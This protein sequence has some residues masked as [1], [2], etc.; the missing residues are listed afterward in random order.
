MRENPEFFR[1]EN[2]KNYKFTQA[3]LS[4]TAKDEHTK[5]NQNQDTNKIAI[6]AK[7]D[8]ESNLKN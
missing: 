4:Q 5:V 2:T 6:R 3:S 7:V 1:P 8:V